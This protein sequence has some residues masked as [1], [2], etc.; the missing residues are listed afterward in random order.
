MKVFKPECRSDIMKFIFSNLVIDAW[1]SL[2]QDVIDSCTV[3]TFKNRLDKYLVGQGLILAI[4]FTFIS[5]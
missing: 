4:E 1:N 3:N 2:P 5:Q